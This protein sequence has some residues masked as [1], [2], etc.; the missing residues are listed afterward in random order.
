MYDSINLLMYKH[1]AYKFRDHCRLPLLTT[2]TKGKVCKGF[3]PAPQLTRCLQ[4]HPRNSSNLSDSKGR[5]DQ[6]V[7]RESGVKI[8]S[9]ISKFHQHGA[10]IIMYLQSSPLPGW[11]SLWINARVPFDHHC[12]Y[13]LQHF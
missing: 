7:D 8:A 13:C 3:F 12:N 2:R 9:R 10:C 1:M 6:P 5:K 11:N 4:S